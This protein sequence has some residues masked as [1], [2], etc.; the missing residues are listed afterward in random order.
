M[1]KVAILVSAVLMSTG[2]AGC[3][4]NEVKTPEIPNETTVETSIETPV[5]ETSADEPIETGN[6]NPEDRAQTRISIEEAKAMYADNE[7]MANIS[8]YFMGKQLPD[9]AM[10]KMSGEADRLSEHLGEPF[11]LEFMASWC[12][13]CQSVQAPIEEYKKLEGSAKVI[14]VA[15]LDEFEAVKTFAGTST[16]DYFHVSESE[17]I[18][19]KYLIN[20]VPIFFMVDG[21]GIIQFIYS[22]DVTPEILAE[23]A[24][25][26]LGVGGMDTSIMPEPPIEDVKP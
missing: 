23:Y 3:Q 16:D 10:V 5:V 22:G 9:V 7:E 26:A 15:V 1:K 8:A 24:E 12:S 17:N 6:E 4:K 14:S 25:K 13:V 11:I 19:E 2:V 18:Q 20:F 21:D